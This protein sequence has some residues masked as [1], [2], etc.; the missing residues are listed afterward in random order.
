MKIQFREAQL[1]STKPFEIAVAGEKA[2]IRNAE[3]T[4][5]GTVLTLNGFIDLAG[6]GQLNLAMKG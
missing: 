6:K 4:G 3:F 1:Q 2:T 5:K